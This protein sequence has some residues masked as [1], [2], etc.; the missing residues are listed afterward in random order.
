MKPKVESSMAGLLMTFFRK[1]LVPSVETRFKGMFGIGDPKN[2]TAGRI[3]VGWW[4]AMF[5]IARFGERGSFV[6]AILPGFAAKALGMN[7]LDSFYQSKA[8]QAR[9]ELMI[10]TL[11]TISFAVLR[12]LVYNDDD[13]EEE[14]SWAALQSMRVM[15]KVNNETRSLMWLPPIGKADDY[16]SNFSTFTTAFNEAKVLSTLFSNTFWYTTAGMFDWEYAKEMGFY[17]RRAGR[18]EKGD[19]KVLAN[20]IKLTGI[21]NILDIWEPEYSVKELYKRKQ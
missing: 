20:L 15:A 3:Q 13:D 8:M 17:E 2:W 18:Y 9:R 5:Q 1:Y 11:A 6:E 7:K 21:E 4:T 16:I 19:P 10:A 14:M 12:G